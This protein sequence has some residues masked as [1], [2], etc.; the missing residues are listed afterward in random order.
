M[1]KQLSKKRP[2]GTGRRRLHQLVS[3]LLEDV[4][5]WQDKVNSWEE[6]FETNGTWTHDHSR[7]AYPVL[8]KIGSRLRSILRAG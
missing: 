5:D 6:P 3:Q 2:G 1:P 8:R 4:Y 7:G